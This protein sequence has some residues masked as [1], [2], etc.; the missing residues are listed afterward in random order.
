MRRQAMWGI[1]ALFASSALFGR[2]SVYVRGELKGF[3]LH[4]DGTFKVETIRFDS[5]RP[6]QLGL[7]SRAL[8]PV[9]AGYYVRAKVESKGPLIRKEVVRAGKG[10]VIFKRE[11]KEGTK[12]VE[13]PGVDGYWMGVHAKEGLWLSYEIETEDGRRVTLRPRLP[14]VRV[15]EVQELKIDWLD[16]IRIAEVVHFLRQKGERIWPGFRADSI[17][18]LL[19]GEEEGVLVNPSKVPS[20]FRP[21]K[22]RSPLDFEIFVGPLS[23]PLE[24]GLAYS[25]PLLE[26]GEWVCFLRR[27]RAWYASAIGREPEGYDS[28]WRLLAILHECFHVFSHQRGLETGLEGMRV[29]TLKE[30][31]ALFHPLNWACEEAEKEILVKALNAPSLPEVRRLLKD[32]FL[33]RH[34]RKARFA[35]A[36]KLLEFLEQ[37]ELSEG[38]AYWAEARGGEEASKDYRPSPAILND[39]TFDGWGTFDLKAFAL[40]PEEAGPLGWHGSEKGVLLILLLER[41]GVDWRS[42]VF[43][44]GRF[45]SRLSLAQ[46]LAEETGLRLPEEP[47]KDQATLQALK[48]WGVEDKTAQISPSP[49]PPLPFPDQAVPLWI[50]V[51]AP[52][53]FLSMLEL[54]G[55][56]FPHAPFL[57]FSG[58]EMHS[59]LPCWVAKKRPSPPWGPPPHGWGR[60]C[61]RLP[62]SKEGAVCIQRKGKGFRLVAEKTEMRV[63]KGRVYLGWGGVWVLVFPPLAEAPSPPMEGMILRQGKGGETKTLTLPQKGW[64]MFPLASL[65]LASQRAEVQEGISIT[66]TVTG[67]FEWEDGSLRYAT[68]PLLPE[69]ASFEGERWQTIEGEEY[70]LE[71][72]VRDPSNS[73]V[74]I[75]LQDE[76]GT[77]LASAEAPPGKTCSIL[78]LKFKLPTG[79]EDTGPLPIQWPI[80]KT[81]PVCE[82]TIRGV[83]LVVFTNKF[84]FITIIELWENH[85][86][87]P[88]VNLK[89]KVSFKHPDGTPAFG[90]TEVRIWEEKKERPKEPEWTGR[91]EWQTVK[92]GFRTYIVEAKC[93]ETGEVQRKTIRLEKSDVEVSFEFAI[94]FPPGILVRCRAGED[95]FKPAYAWITITDQTG[96][97]IVDSQGV[98]AN[99]ELRVECPPGK[100]IVEAQRPK[101]CHLKKEVEVVEKP[102][103]KSRDEAL[104]PVGFLLYPH[105][106][107]ITI[108]VQFKYKDGTEAY[109]TAEI[110]I[111]R[112]GEERPQEPTQWLDGSA[113]GI[114]MGAVGMN[115]IEARCLETGETKTAKI[116]IAEHQHIPL[117][118]LIFTFILPKPSKGQK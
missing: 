61:L 83:R 50:V 86:C 3:F 103:A 24:D 104:T 8:Y 87:R 53:Q 4:A 22:G 33:I 56:F 76:N 68:L 17:P 70:E 116:I 110:R 80:K 23:L 46:I 113:E 20:G 60:L 105:Y 94:P 7:K 109:G 64:L 82:E 72:E 42:K 106:Y 6:P 45:V 111:W 30:I 31:E 77:V 58:F 118:P 115:I 85:I 43:Q 15:D 19:E 51:E 66:T 27:T 2:P 81:C 114:F 69:G 107:N 78:K 54:G 102:K 108:K 21:F 36:K 35:Q 16:L 11:V 95:P 74:R 97:K 93:L 89:I 49:S 73:L 117:P 84:P 112:E 100:Y 96:R 25:F 92:T 41:L 9:W 63:E 10:R 90:S 29:E 65:L 44:K 18:F 71:A 98:D 52:K 79:V 101:G 1:A 39:P 75:E 13:L 57:Q 32:F 34:Y 26:T 47:L 28:G 12:E 40:S 59:C 62:L 99:G 14:R 55:D 67:N 91:G 38:L 37:R 88:K 5:R 48:R